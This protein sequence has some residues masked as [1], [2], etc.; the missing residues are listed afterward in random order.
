MWIFTLDILIDK[1]MYCVCTYKRT[2]NISF[3]LA[4]EML[5]FL[6]ILKYT[7]K[8][9]GCNAYFQYFENTSLIKELKRKRVE[10]GFLHSP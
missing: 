10:N 5:S 4:N 2:I 8:Y 9:D 1:A 6:R 7:F 3:E